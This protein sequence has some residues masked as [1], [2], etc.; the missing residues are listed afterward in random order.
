MT[1]KNSPQKTDFAGLFD[2]GFHVGLDKR[3][4]DQTK[5]HKK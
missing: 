3:L 1:D 2:H 5:D 4:Q